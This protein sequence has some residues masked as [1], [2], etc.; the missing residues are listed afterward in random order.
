MT[1]TTTTP[2]APSLPPAV[3]RALCLYVPA[4]RL[5]YVVVRWRDGDRV[6]L[7]EG[8]T[9]AGRVRIRP[10]IAARRAYGP[11]QHVAPARVLRLAT[12]DDRRKRRVERPPVPAGV[13]E[14][15]R[16]LAPRPRSRR[17]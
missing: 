13:A 7:A 4:G 17:A 1:S 3:V 15:M 5:V 10:W 6:A 2:A 12:P 11:A 16:G 14:L 9:A 8:T